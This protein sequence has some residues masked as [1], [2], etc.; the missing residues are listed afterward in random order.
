MERGRK[1]SWAQ[2][3]EWVGEEMPGAWWRVGGRG[4]DHQK[5]NSA[6]FSILPD[7]NLRERD[8]ERG[9]GDIHGLVSRFRDA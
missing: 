3:A 8:R 1:S 5:P 7:L 9:F 6:N 2:K 4:N